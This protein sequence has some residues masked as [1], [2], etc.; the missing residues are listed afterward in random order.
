MIDLSSQFRELKNI[1]MS[2]KGFI[3]EVKWLIEEPPQM[4]V[5]GVVNEQK[6]RESLYRDMRNYFQFTHCSMNQLSEKFGYSRTMCH[7]IV[8]SDSGYAPQRRGRVSRQGDLRLKKNGGGVRFLKS[9]RNKRM[10]EMYTKD[11]NTL[12]QIADEF[13]CSRQNIEQTFLNHFRDEY[14]A[15]LAIRKGQSSPKPYAFECKHCH[16]TKTII[17]SPR[18]YHPKFCSAECRAAGGF[19][20]KRYFTI[21]QKRAAW[22]IRTKKYYHSVLKFKPEFKAKSKLY[23]SSQNQKNAVK[24]W[25][26]K[27]LA[28]HRELVKQVLESRNQL[29]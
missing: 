11:K 22:N 20:P 13:K 14:K 26:A 29:K 6:K 2:I 24:K 4:H 1:N 9:E 12:Q 16:Q 25:Q 17:V 19:I 5:G 27:K 8:N 15:E 18:G 7:R 28:K 3:Q 23:N 21:E 10:F